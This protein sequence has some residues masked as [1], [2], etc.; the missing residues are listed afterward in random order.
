MFDNMPEPGSD[1]KDWESPIDDD[2]PHASTDKLD[3]VTITANETA[4][5]GRLCNKFEF[6]II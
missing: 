4:N 5:I 1:V 2:I 6:I 3:K